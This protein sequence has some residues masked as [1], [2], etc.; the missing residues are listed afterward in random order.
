MNTN[1]CVSSLSDSDL[2]A[3]YERSAAKLSPSLDPDERVKLWQ[4]IW[5]L[6][7]ELQR[8]YSAAVEPGAS[9]P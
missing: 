6:N 5:V 3:A 9:S 2:H 8:R 7:S 1:A 4:E